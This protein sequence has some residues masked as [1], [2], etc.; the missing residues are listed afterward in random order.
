MHLKK[1]NSRKRVIEIVDFKFIKNIILA[2]FYYIK[3][4]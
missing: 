3:I 2:N 4:S 1:E